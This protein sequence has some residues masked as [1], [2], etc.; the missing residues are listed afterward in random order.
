MERGPDEVA[1]PREDGLALER[2]DW[3]A[4]SPRPRNFRCPNE[5]AAERRI[6][7][8]YLDLGLKGLP[9]P[10]E[11]VPV[12]RHVHEP[13]E[14][15]LRL[16]NLAVALLGEEDA[17]GARPQ[18][19]HPLFRAS[20]DVVEQSE[21]HEELRDRRALA[22]RHRQGVDLREIRRSADGEGI[23]GDA[24]LLHRLSDRVHMLADVS[25]D[26]DDTDPHWRSKA[27]V[28]IRF[29]GLRRG[30]A[31]PFPEEGLEDLCELFGVLQQA[32]RRDPVDDDLVPRLK[33]RERAPYDLVPRREDR[34]PCGGSR[35]GVGSTF[36]EG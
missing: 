11:G 30:S 24:R 9:L 25:L 21:L 17:P 7:H 18:D 28:R 27:A 2:S 1:L 32:L 4:T 5:H 19:R 34:L 15:G 29:R 23:A 10:T 13:E 31:V 3:H 33:H 22:A 8:G 35:E 26:A 20:D 12:H 14:A 16:R 6:E 36:V